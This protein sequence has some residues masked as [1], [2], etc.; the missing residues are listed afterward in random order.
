MVSIQREG[1][2]RKTHLAAHLRGFIMWLLYHG[3]ARMRTK[4]QT[5]HWVLLKD[6]P[7][8]VSADFLMD[9]F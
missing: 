8:M 1:T 7:S 3:L 2:V 9:T 6:F 4:L 5:W